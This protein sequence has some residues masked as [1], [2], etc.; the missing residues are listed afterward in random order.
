MKKNHKYILTKM[1]GGCKGSVT[2][3]FTELLP[4]SRSDGSYRVCLAISEV[5]IEVEKF[6]VEK[7]TKN[8]LTLNPNPTE[9]DTY[10]AW[11]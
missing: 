1:F 11:D 8:Y 6:Y 2:K 10:S 3:K 5:E 9:N 7:M 4:E